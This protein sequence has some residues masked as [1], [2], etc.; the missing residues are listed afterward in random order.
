MR[1]LNQQQ[2]ARRRVTVATQP[3]VLADNSVVESV[4]KVCCIACSWLMADGG[5]LQLRNDEV[6]ADALCR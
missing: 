2:R 5:A 4:A 6:H 1:Y 3:D